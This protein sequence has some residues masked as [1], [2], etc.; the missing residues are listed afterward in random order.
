[1]WW[2]RCKNTNKSSA[3]IY[4]RKSLLSLNFIEQNAFP[5]KSLILNFAIAR[6]YRIP[7]KIVESCKI[8][9][10]Q[11]YS[12]GLIGISKKAW[13]CSLS[14]IVPQC[15]T[16]RGWFTWHLSTFCILFF[17]L[18]ILPCT[19]YLHKYSTPVKK[20]NLIITELWAL[21]SFGFISDF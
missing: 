1:M 9:I 18:D 6:F 11:I 20:F 21:I 15:R 10:F 4:N 12:L 8:F 5:F 16:K 2:I 19:T 3:K 13:I 7:W 14:V 17:A